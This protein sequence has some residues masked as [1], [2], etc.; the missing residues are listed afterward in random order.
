VQ[1]DPGRRGDAFC[2]RLADALRPEFFC[3]DGWRFAYRTAAGVPSFVVSAG[4]PAGD[5]ASCFLHLQPGTAPEVFARLVSALDGYGVGFRAELAGD[6]ASCVRTDT[7]V[8]TVDRSDASALARLA[9]RVHQ[10]SPFAL[11]PAV[12]AFTRRLAPGIALADEPGPGPGT[13]F[14]RH[15]CRLVA[16]GLV[17]AGP[18]AGPAG[19]RAAVLELLARAGLD[20]AALHLNPGNPEFRV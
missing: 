12:P 1:T 8:V 5:T 9:L 11:A 6:P 19:R 7:A 3:R 4:T 20:P 10:R 13:T 14:G 2:R 18:G 15:R 17:A 16:A